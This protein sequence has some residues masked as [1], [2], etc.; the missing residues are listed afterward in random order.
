MKIYYIPIVIIL[1]LF[2]I[3][4]PNP[5][6]FHHSRINTKYSY[7][8]PPRPNPFKYPLFYF[9][10]PAVFELHP[11]EVLYIP[12][13]W[14]HWVFSKGENIAINQWFKT[15]KSDKPF[16]FINKNKLD[17]TNFFNR[18]DGMGMGLAQNNPNIQS[19]VRP[20]AYPIDNDE[21]KFMGP[22]KDFMEI[23]KDKKYS[24][25][26][27]EGQLPKEFIDGV[28]DRVETNSKY[29]LWYY[30]NDAN[31]GL[32]YDN[33]GN[34]LCQIKGTK[35]IYLFPPSDSKFLYGDKIL[36]FND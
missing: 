15:K 28:P 17:L 21:I 24:G 16:K 4:R 19:Y 14:W 31:S 35:K 9:T 32:H 11:G 1:I 3:Y 27:I 6:I 23:S 12:Y 10:C 5:H 26:V 33:Y 18:V 7:D 34:F 36:R 20:N 29:N 30:S 22:L 25:F 8:S 2:V 13:G